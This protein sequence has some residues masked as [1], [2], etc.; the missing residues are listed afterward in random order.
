MGAA[1]LDG[2][3]LL[4][5]VPALQT[6]EQSGQPYADVDHIAPELFDRQEQATV[7]V[8]QERQLAPK[9]GIVGDQ[10]Q[11][12]KDGVRRL[13][14]VQEDVSSLRC[15]VGL[16]PMPVAAV[17]LAPVAARLTVAGCG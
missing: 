16:H 1:H 2:D 15:I 17:H 7:D 14:I 9:R 12:S 5:D 6:L 13:E 8:F 10:S 4:W 11:H 3:V